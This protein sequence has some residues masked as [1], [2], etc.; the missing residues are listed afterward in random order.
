MMFLFKINF[1]V[2]SHKLTFINHIPVLAYWERGDDRINGLE[3][4]CT[5]FIKGHFIAGPK[6]NITR[7]NRSQ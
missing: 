6:E 2:C 7:I 4:P 1:H 3:A 5:Y